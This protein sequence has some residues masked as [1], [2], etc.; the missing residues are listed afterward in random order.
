[1]DAHRASFDDHMAPSRTAHLPFRLRFTLPVLGAALYM[2]LVAAIYLGFHPRFAPSLSALLAVPWV[3]TLRALG[4]VVLLW[5]AATAYGAPIVS[6]LW[7]GAPDPLATLLTS[8][9]VGFGA[10]AYGTFFVGIAH[11]L[12][13]E[14]AFALILA[15]LALWHRRLWRTLRAVRASA[16]EPHT[17]RQP[18]ARPDFGELGRALGPLAK[19]ALI[20]I[21]AYALWRSFVAALVPPIEFDA[22]MYHLGVPQKFIEARAVVF[23]PDV[24][25]ANLHLNVDMLYVV[26]MLLDGVMAAKLLNW[27]LGVALGATV[28]ALGRTYF[29]R[30]VALLAAALY[31]TMPIIADEL[32]VRVH[33]D[34]G[35]AWFV[36]LAVLVFLGWQ[37]AMTQAKPG[38]S[39]R[40]VLALTAIL[41]GIA[42]GSKLN[43][44][45]WLGGATLAV[46]AVSWRLRGPAAALGQA[47]ALFALAAVFDLPWLVRNLINIG[48]PFDFFLTSIF[49][50]GTY[51]TDHDLKRFGLAA[52]LQGDAPWIKVLR[53]P[54]DVTMNA[55]T[56]YRAKA[57]LGPAPLALLPVLA[58]VW[59]LRR[60]ASG[61]AP[62]TLLWILGFVVFYVPFWL[63]QSPGLRYFIGYGLLALGGA[64]AVVAVARAAPRAIAWVPYL[65]AAGVLTASL[66]TWK[67]LDARATLGARNHDAFYRFR[68]FPGDGYLQTY[69]V[70]KFIDIHLPP[71]AVIYHHLDEAMTLFRTRKTIGGNFGPRGKSLHLIDPVLEDYRPGEEILR[72]LRRL[73]AT[74]L[75]INANRAYRL[76]RPVPDDPYWR[77]NVRV[78]YADRGVMLYDLWPDGRP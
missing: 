52:A 8:A 37:R 68:R 71:D 70:W 28:W 23:L 45:V 20:G 58:V 24:Q 5:L 46:A 35:V 53:F 34:L 78:L 77:D 9:A 75:L 49:G 38:G 31:T 25:G 15:P 63:V 50:Q 26:A 17:R 6:R 61:C 30:D 19:A 54:W 47:A 56:M 11:W 72:N 7:R 14:A 39:A 43:G 62:V 33:A 66:L 13:P 64:Y 69:E 76:K 16:P 65:G 40:G 27:S 59:W 55:L 42:V 22:L 36:T 41:F 48:T 32:A 60:T 29:G 57:P 18:S 67:P 51:Y 73:G 74:H 12:I 1:M 21:V 10:L 3:V 4:T 44:W 2:L